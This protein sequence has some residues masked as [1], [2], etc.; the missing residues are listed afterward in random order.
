MTVVKDVDGQNHPTSPGPLIAVGDPVTFTYLVTNTGN[1][2]LTPVTVTDNILGTITCPQTSLAPGASETCTRAAGNSVAGNHKNTATVTG[3]GVGDTGAPVGSPVSATDTANYF[4]D[5]PAIT[6]TKDV[7][8]EH[9]PTAPGLSSGGRVHLA[10]H[11]CGHQH[12]Q[13]HR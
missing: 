5:A 4:G 9:E 10:L 7:D 2:T 11:L 3:Q 8:G 12:R 6:R 1:V 13:C